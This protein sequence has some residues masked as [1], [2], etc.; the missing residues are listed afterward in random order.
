MKEKQ[1]SNEEIEELDDYLA[2]G[3]NYAIYN[4]LCSID[5]DCYKDLFEPLEFFRLLYFQI[6]FIK[7]NKTKPLLGVIIVRVC[8]FLIFLIRLNLEN[9]FG[10]QNFI[11]IMNGII[12]FLMMKPPSYQ[13]AKYLKKSEKMLIKSLLKKMMA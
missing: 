7:A 9:G 10:F 6:D 2:T 5:N 1:Y 11:R 12:K 3:F 8:K 13:Q 4:E